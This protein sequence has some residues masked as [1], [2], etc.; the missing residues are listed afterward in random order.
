MVRVGGWKDMRPS[1]ILHFKKIKSKIQG[2]R[3]LFNKISK[4]F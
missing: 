4:F 3:F 2:A 1:I